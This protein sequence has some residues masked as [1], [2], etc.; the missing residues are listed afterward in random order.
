MKFYLDLSPFFT[1]VGNARFKI[2]QRYK[3]QLIPSTENETSAILICCYPI[4]HLDYN[5]SNTDYLH[6]PYVN[7]YYSR[8]S[9]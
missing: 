6:K 5:Q 4:I 8:T 7:L 2:Y 9:M 3:R 1:M